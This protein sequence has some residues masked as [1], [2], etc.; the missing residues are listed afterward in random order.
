MMNKNSSNHWLMTKA[1]IL[2]VLMALAVVAFAKPKSDALPSTN[3]Q[4]SSMKSSKADNNSIYS[5]VEVNADFKGGIDECYKWIDNT[6]H[7]PEEAIA[8]K[9][10]GRVFVKFVVEKDGHIS[11]PKVLRSP[12]KQLSE[13]ALRIVKLMPAWEPAMIEGKPVRSY[14]TLPI[15]FKLPKK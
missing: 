4:E 13:E 9:I 12:D 14:L 7:Y 1:V 6:I 10:Q 8:K 11:Q 5:E 3:E 2:P 15:M